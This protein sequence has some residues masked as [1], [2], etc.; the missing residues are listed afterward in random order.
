MLV[1]LPNILTVLRI[2]LVPVF[3]IA[4][5]LPGMTARLIAFAVFT[6][7]GL[8]DALDGL[9]A[10][11]LNAGSDFGRMLDP[12][13]DKILVGVALMM[14][15]AGGS[16]DGWKLVPALVILAREI[17]VS[18]LREFLAGA[19]V[20]VPVSFFA[21]IKTTIQM[22]A[23]GAMILGP[24][25]DKIVPGALAFAY[26]ALWVAAGLTVATGYVYLRAGLAHTRPRRETAA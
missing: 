11:K 18:G 25:A 10:R 23:I 6:I 16:F 14:L 12:I 19:D 20:S 7:A 22:I 26:V 8:S 1:G 13:A 4:F 17:L 24:M 2:A 21:K 15:V 3:A 5:A 9:A